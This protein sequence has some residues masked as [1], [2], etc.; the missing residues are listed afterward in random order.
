MDFC[1]IANNTKRMISLSS[2]VISYDEYSN[3]SNKY[4]NTFNSC[5]LWQY[6]HRHNTKKTTEKK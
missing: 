1:V 2:G 6:K 5:E 4:Q 3:H